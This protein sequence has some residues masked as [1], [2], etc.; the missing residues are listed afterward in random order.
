ME[1]QERRLHEAQD[2]RGRV[3]QHAQLGWQ[4]S[5]GSGGRGGGRPVARS[6]CVREFSGPRHVTFGS[7]P[8]AGSSSASRT[9]MKRTPRA[10]QADSK[11]SSV[12][13]TKALT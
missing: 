5:R 9:G 7:I 4:R 1:E 10:S 8:Y 12:S 11:S 6:N 2:E 13:A 3:E